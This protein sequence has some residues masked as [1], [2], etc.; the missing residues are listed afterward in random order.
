MTLC[1]G[2]EATATVAYYNSGSL[3]W[4]GGRMG[5][6]AYLGT[7]NPS[8]GQDQPSALGGDGTH[9]S[10]DTGW[11]RYNR[12]ATQPAAYVGPGQIAWFQFRVRAPQTPGR[13]TLALRPLIEGSSWLEDYG[14]FW[15]ITVPNPD[16]SLPPS[17]TLSPLHVAGNALVNEAGAPVQLRGVNRSGTEYACI[18]GWGISDGPSDLASVQA[19][20]SWKTNAVRVPLNEDCWLNINGAPVAYAGG[21][22]QRAIADYVGLLN[23]AGLYAILELHWSAPGTTLATGQSSMPDRDHSVALWTSVASAFRS[24]GAVILEPFNEPFPDHNSD[25]PSAWACWRDGGSCGVSVTGAPFEA[26][27]MQELITAIRQTGARN[28]IAVGGVQYSNALG[29]WLDHRPTDPIGNLVAAWHMY[30]FNICSTTSCFDSTVGPV[31]AA[32]PIIATEVGTDDCSAA[33]ITAALNWLEQ[34]NIGYLAWTWDTWGSGCGS[35]ALVLDYSGTPTPYGL[36][37]RSY[38][39][40]R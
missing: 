1:P 29:G 24:N 34:R 35:I 5:E 22:Y 9:G 6:V 4:V 7:W 38:L 25:T 16:G 36:A 19:I 37:F 31:A 3:G 18:Q 20:A 21:A 32:V 27:G 12:L 28:V 39:A 17:G 26:A 23:Q 14:V 30:N 2:T 40:A 15:A 13:Y 10:P 8:P 11:P 33:F